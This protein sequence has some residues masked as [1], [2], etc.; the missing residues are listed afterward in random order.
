MASCGTNGS[1]GILT[2]LMLK[3]IC[4]EKFSCEQTLL[5]ER[6]LEIILTNYLQLFHIL[7]RFSDIKICLICK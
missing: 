4:I 5:F 2:H 1:N 6:T 7:L 3:C